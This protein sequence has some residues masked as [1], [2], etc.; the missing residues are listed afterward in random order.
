MRCGRGPGYIYTV[1]R[2]RTTSTI[3]RCDA[4]SMARASGRVR[5]DGQTWYRARTPYFLIVLARRGYGGMASKWNFYLPYAVRMRMHWFH[6]IIPV[7][8]PARASGARNVRAHAPDNKNEIKRSWARAR[9]CIV[10][11]IAWALSSHII[12]NFECWWSLHFVH[13]PLK[14]TRKSLWLKC[15]CRAKIGARRVN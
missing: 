12:L 10:Y 9:G 1:G 5:I 2:R 7:A 6:L 13:L 4:T 8:R 11:Y 15:T 14:L 3:R